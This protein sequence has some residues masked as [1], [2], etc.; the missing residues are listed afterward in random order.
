VAAGSGL[1]NESM[2][3]GEERSVEKNIGMKVYG[4]TILSRGSII[5][6]VSKLAENAVVNQLIKLVENA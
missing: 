3:T 2:L 5:V 6:R 1:C 4:G